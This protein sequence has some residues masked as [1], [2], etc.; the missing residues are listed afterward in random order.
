MFKKSMLALALT[1]SAGMVH[2]AGEIDIQGSFFG[3]TYASNPDVAGLASGAVTLETLLAT[4]SR[5]VD[6]AAAPFGARSIVYSPN[7]NISQNSTITF[8]VT[9]GAILAP[10]NGAPALA[11]LYDQFAGSV[12]GN[13]ID[14]TT[15]AAGNYTTLR[16]QIVGA[17]LVSTEGYNIGYATGDDAIV[18]TNAGLAAGQSVSIAAISAQ[19]PSA[20]AIAQGVAPA[21]N[22][23]T[24]IAGLASTVTVATSV[25]DVEADPSRTAFVSEGLATDT[26]DTVSSVATITTTNSAEITFDLTEADYELTVTRG[27]T[28]NVT[29]SIFN[30]GLLSATRV[31]TGVDA[32]DD[33]LGLGGLDL[34]LSVNGSGVLATG[35]WAVNLVLDTEEL[36]TDTTLL[37]AATS[38]RWSINGAQ[39]KIPYHAQN[40]T[41]FNF[42]FNAVNESANP[43]ALA[44]DVIVQ[45]TTAGTSC[46]VDG[47]DLGTAAAESSF[48]VGQAAIKTAINAEGTC[49]LDDSSIYHVAMTVTAVAPTNQVQFAAF[50][51]DAVGRTVVPVYVNTRTL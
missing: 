25:I 46:S 41:G 18:R 35:D 50:Q 24:V 6:M 5:T 39:V 4:T 38:H 51:K 33:L 17:D 44:A 21:E 3:G 15:D 14:F 28:A 20:I 37:N 42:F 36:A 10:A 30:G 16:F 19:D 13:L 31:H 27:D 12:V 11:A 26:P 8:Q 48:T 9:N 49:A 2:A 34:E 22:V 47:V 29:G 23:V 40:A 32:A 45:N 43:A 1:A 7:T